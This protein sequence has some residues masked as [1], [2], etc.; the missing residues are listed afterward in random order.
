[1]Y[2]AYFKVGMS[3]KVTEARVGMG[4]IEKCVVRLGGM[5]VVYNS[6]N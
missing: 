3:F 6:P 5:V 1:M 4:W 2:R